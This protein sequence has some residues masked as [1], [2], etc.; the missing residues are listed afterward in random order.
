MTDAV[1]LTPITALHW[2]NAA[3]VA[4]A[5]LYEDADKIGLDPSDDTNVHNLPSTQLHHPE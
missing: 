3:R 1:R 5:I 2:R 4:I